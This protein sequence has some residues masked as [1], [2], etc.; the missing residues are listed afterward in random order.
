MGFIANLFAFSIYS[1]DWY[2]AICFLKK[3]SKYILSVET[4]QF[5]LDNLINAAF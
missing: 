2:I 4:L 5:G 1:K 3:L